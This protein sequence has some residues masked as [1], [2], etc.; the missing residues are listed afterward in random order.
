[1]AGRISLR[2]PG[3]FERWLRDLAAA[4]RKPVRGGIFDALREYRDRHQEQEK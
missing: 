1:M 3:E 2:L 4:I